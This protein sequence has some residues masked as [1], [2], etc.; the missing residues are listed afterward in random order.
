M[1]LKRYTQTSGA[2]VETFNTFDGAPSGEWVRYDDI[3]HLLETRAEVRLNDDG[4]LDEVVCRGDQLEQMDFNHWFLSMGDV[5]VWLHSKNAIRASY[6]HRST[7]AEG[8]QG[9]KK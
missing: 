4:T 2:L 8:S 1:K 7:A 6:E 5:A 9:E 3:K